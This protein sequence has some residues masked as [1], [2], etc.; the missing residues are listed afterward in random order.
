M[1]NV[2]AKFELKERD[3]K[4]SGTKGAKQEKEMKRNEATRMRKRKAM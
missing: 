1:E 2:E 4:S 3:S